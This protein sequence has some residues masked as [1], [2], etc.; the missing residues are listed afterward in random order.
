MY[1]TDP[2]PYDFPVI[3]N[4]IKKHFKKLI[5]KKTL[6]KNKFRK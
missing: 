4:P 2:N 6:R 3:I 1:N 5:L